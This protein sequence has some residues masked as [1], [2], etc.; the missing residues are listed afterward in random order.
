MYPYIK[1]QSAYVMLRPLFAPIRSR[2]EVPYE[3]YLSAENWELDLST[4]RFPGAPLGRG[5]ELNDE[6]HPHLELE[7]TMISVPRVGPGDQAW[8]H[9]GESMLFF[10]LLLWISVAV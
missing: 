6:T 3:E 10:I 9:C 2:A 1:E 4:S 8:W 7:R 5:Q